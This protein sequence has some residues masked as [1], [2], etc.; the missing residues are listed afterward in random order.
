MRGINLSFTVSSDDKTLT[1]VDK[2][3]AADGSR[4]E[5]T[6]AYARLAP[7]KSIFGEW[8][9]VSMKDKSSGKPEMF[10]I[11]L[12]GKDGLSFISPATQHRTQMN[13]DGKVYF[14][15]DPATRSSVDFRKE[16]KCPC[17]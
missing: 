11:E 2:F 1:L 13:F 3:T 5:T 12:Y 10:V 15:E 7:G 16:D 14:D 6:T 9:S 4:E 8:Q 17:P